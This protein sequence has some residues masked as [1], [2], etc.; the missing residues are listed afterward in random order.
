MNT[1]HVN[2]VS[3]LFQKPVET[4]KKGRFVCPVCG[5]DYATR[6]GIFRH[7]EK[8]DCAPAD[9]LFADTV[10]ERIGYDFFISSAPE[11]NKNQ[12]KGLSVFRKSK[13]YRQVLMYVLHCMTNKADPYMFYEWAKLKKKPRYYNHILSLMMKDTSL[14]EFREHL[15]Q[16]EELIDSEKFYQAN[17]EYLLSNTAFLVRSLE[18]GDIG[19]DFC[20]NHPS[21]DLTS[22]VDAFPEATKIH[23]L[24]V[25]TIKEAA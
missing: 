1:E 24:K 11:F 17:E 3:H 23:L 14:V 8:Q 20:M 15:I 10:T 9:L 13:Y 25:L 21:V 16:N 6:A 19:L 2:D 7:M 5:K 22:R 4:D 12:R 18:R